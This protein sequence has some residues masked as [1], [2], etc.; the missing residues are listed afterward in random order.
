MIRQYRGWCV[1]G[2]E[3]VYGSGANLNGFIFQESMLNG[4][5]DGVNIY[6]V[7][8]KSIGQSTGLKDKNGV[9]IF[10]GDILNLFDNGLIGRGAVYFR[11]QDAA[12]FVRFQEIAEGELTG[13]VRPSKLI[14]TF[15]HV[16]IIGNTCENPEL[17]ERWS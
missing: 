8:P 4:D 9:E 16:E 17:L 13:W 5:C 3:W 15:E 14:T 12:F 6:E 2:K 1:K 10:E 11:N 7:D